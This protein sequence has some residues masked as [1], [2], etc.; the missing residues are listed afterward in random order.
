MSPSA[1]PTSR[2]AEA[3]AQ[4]VP[5]DLLQDGEVVILALKPSGW[6]VIIAS[7]PIVASAALVAGLAYVVNL[8]HP[9]T[10]L[11]LICSA[12]A[13]VAL[14]RTVIACWQWLGRT[15]VLTNRR[16]VCIRGLLRVQ[17]SAAGLAG[18]RETL[19]TS[20]IAERLVGTGSIFCLGD[21]EGLPLVT[22]HSVA[23]P[24]EIHEIVLEAVNRARR[25]KTPPAGLR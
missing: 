15:Y 21:P 12:C 9:P 23:R 22:W 1:E 18:I 25:N 6:F 10:Q 2:R 5:V 7:L 19:L 17:W 3:P 20:A 13:A 11:R 8:Y 16:I 24:A 14:L 4:L